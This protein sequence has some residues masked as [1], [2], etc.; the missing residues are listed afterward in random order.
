MNPFC[1]LNSRSPGE[2]KGFEEKWKVLD[3][4]FFFMNVQL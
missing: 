1:T 3:L 2:N 4:F